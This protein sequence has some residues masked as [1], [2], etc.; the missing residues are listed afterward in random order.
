MIGLIGEL[1]WRLPRQILTRQTLQTRRMFRA[2]RGNAKVLLATNTFWMVPISFGGTYL[3]LFMAEQGL[4][5]V[6]IGT[7]TSTQLGAQILGS[8][9]GGWIADRLGW[10]K[11]LQILDGTI[12]PAIFLSFAFAHGYF[13]FFIGSFLVGFQSC[14]WP[15]FLSLLLEGVPKS[16]S[17]F[18][19]ALEQ[20][21]WFAGGV[22]TSVTGLLVS[23]WGVSASSRTVFVSG[24][25]LM[26][27]GWTIR[28]RMVREV[29]APRE[30]L[31]PPLLV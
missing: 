3:P 14:A 26:S 9:F 15:A 4:S 6:E 16:K 23:R 8:F 2:A 29:A 18:I 7:L 22:L 11:A 25:F 12:W 13:L 21:T 19:F 28:Q 5:K 1:V 27:I 20:V 31:K 10:K 30:K 24:C 17:A